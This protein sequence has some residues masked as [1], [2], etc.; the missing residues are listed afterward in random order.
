MKD[1]MLSRLDCFTASAEICFHCF[2]VMQVPVQWRHPC[3]ELRENTRLSFAELVV[4]APS[5]AARPP[6]VDPAHC[7]SDRCRHLHHRLHQGLL[8]FQ[9]DPLG[10]SGSVTGHPS[11]VS[12]SLRELFRSLP[13]LEDGAEW[14]PRKYN[15]DAES[16]QEFD[17]FQNPTYDP[18]PGPFGEGP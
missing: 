13:E 14:S 15:A 4:H 5:V 6:S 11:L 1:E 12:G 18:L 16:F 2:D 7:V 10:Q 8:R 17:M 9:N 3:A